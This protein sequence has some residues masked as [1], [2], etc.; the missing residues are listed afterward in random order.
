MLRITLLIKAL[1]KNLID[2]WVFFKSVS[3][4]ILFLRVRLPITLLISRRSKCTQYLKLSIAKIGIGRWQ[5][6]VVLFG[7]HMICTS[8]QF[9]RWIWYLGRTEVCESCDYLALTV[10]GGMNH[11]GWLTGYETWAWTSCEW[12]L[13]TYLGGLSNAVSLQSLGFVDGYLALDYFLFCD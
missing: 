6:T 9:D 8:R 7:Y 3:D 13:G 5:L 4:C 1:I 10:L 11:V 12:L 2:K